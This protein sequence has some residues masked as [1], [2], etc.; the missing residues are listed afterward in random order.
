MEVWLLNVIQDVE[1]PGC[2]PDRF[3]PVVRNA[4]IAKHPV[5]MAIEVHERI[6]LHV[7]VCVSVATADNTPLG[8]SPMPSE[9][10]PGY[11]GPES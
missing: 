2:E 7:G 8:V 1:H 4:V 3:G 10:Q 6:C 5:H 9:P 11:P